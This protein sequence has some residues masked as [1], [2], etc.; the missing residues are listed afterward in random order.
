VIQIQLL[1]L[2]QMI[3]TGKVSLT[4]AFNGEGSQIGK[5]LQVLIRF[6]IGRNGKLGNAPELIGKDR[7]GAAG[8]HST[9]D[10]GLHGGISKCDLL[11]HTLNGIATDGQRAHKPLLIDSQ[12]VY[13]RFT[14]GEGNRASV[15]V[16]RNRGI[17]G[18]G[19]NIKPGAVSA[20]RNRNVLGVEAGFGTHDRCLRP[21]GFQLLGNAGIGYT[22]HQVHRIH[23]LILQNKYTTQGG[24]QLGGGIRAD[25]AGQGILGLGV[26]VH[27]QI[28]LCQLNG[29][30]IVLAGLVIGYI[31]QKRRDIIVAGCLEPAGMIQQKFFCKGLVIYQEV[32][33]GTGDQCQCQQ[34][35]YN[36]AK[37]FFH[38]VCSV[39][40]ILC[41][42]L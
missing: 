2:F 36:N 41:Y 19:A 13:H 6:G 21:H 38:S 23:Q 24:I 32:P 25:G 27:V 5:I 30:G 3:Q 42:Y 10:G 28:L 15:C 37:R 29:Y 8:F 14:G 22:V 33:R 20:D 1:Q 40:N 7:F 17:I 18:V 26:I 34:Q 9:A 31:I 39:S 16:F 11:H 35:R 4:L 12:R